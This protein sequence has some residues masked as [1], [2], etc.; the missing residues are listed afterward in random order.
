MYFVNEE[1]F[2]TQSVINNGEQIEIPWGGF[3]DYNEFS[4]YRKK[5]IIS[6]SILDNTLPIKQKTH[7]IEWV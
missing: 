5:C 2:R 7:S 6:L 1:Y 3:P 4:F